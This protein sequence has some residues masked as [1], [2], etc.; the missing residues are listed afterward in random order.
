M[1]SCAPDSSPRMINAWQ[2]IPTCYV[3][4]IFV[5]VDKGANAAGLP[6]PAEYYSQYSQ[7]TASN[8]CG[9]NGR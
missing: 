6:T 8:N 2:F 7:Y 4:A 3:Q 1:W 5:N 9:H